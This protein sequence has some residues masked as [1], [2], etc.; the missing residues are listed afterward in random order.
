MMD[1]GGLDSAVRVTVA[2]AATTT[3]CLL[4]IATPIAWWLSRGKDLVRD[5]AT[6]LFSNT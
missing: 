1:W 5:I 4:V 3:L 2:L 6:A